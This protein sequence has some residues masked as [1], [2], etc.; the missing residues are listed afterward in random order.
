MTAPVMIECQLDPDCGC[1]EEVW[2]GL[3]WWGLLAL[4]I[5]ADGAVID[6]TAILGEDETEVAL[7]V[8]GQSRES[9]FEALIALCES[10]PEEAL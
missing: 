1:T 7:P 6:A 4:H 5:G 3:H 2:E 9:A 10:L 8:S